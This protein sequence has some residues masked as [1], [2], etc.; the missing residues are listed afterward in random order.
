VALRDGQSVLSVV[1]AVTTLLEEHLGFFLCVSLGFGLIWLAR[2]SK[3]NS[4]K[5]LC[6]K[7]APA[8]CHDSA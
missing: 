4:I 6:V 1:Q 2:L 3:W 7:V 8:T 5:A